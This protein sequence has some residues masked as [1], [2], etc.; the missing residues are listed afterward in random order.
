MSDGRQLFK[1][2]IWEWGSAQKDKVED[3]F[4]INNY[5]S[6]HLSSA[7]GSVVQL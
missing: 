4:F 2:P 1:I 6:D 5:V 7:S 3:F